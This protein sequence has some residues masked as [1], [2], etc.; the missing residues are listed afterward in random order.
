MKKSII[1]IFIMLLFS[2]ILWGQRVF[3][4]DVFG[5]SVSANAFLPTKMDFYSAVKCSLE[6]NNEIRAIRKA[7]AAT[8]KDVGIARSNMLPHAR[9]SETFEATNN[10][11]EAF[12]LKLNQTRATAK[13][14]SLG[15]LDYP[16]GVYNF[17]TTL[18]LEQMILN[19]KAMVTI[20][21]AKK[22]YSASEYAYIRK[23]EELIN[24]VAQTCLKIN[25]IKE[26]IKV[27][28]QGIKDANEHLEIAKERHSKNIGDYADVFRA[29]TAV[30][31]RE[32]KLISANKNL[33]ITQRALGLLLGMENP[34]EIIDSVPEVKLNTMC[35]YKNLALFRSDVIA[36]EVRVENAKNN[37][38]FEQA[39]W[40]PTLNAVASYNF[41]DPYYPFGGLGNNY[42][43]AAFLRWDIFDG[44]KRNYGVA[45]AKYKEEE[46][47]E[48]LEGFKKGVNFRI[49]EVYS[50]VVEHQ[51]NL[52]LA[53]ARKKA[54]EEGQILTEKDWSNSK[55]PFVSVIESQ[56]SLDATR[57]NL[58]NNQFDLQEDLITL[59]Y[60]SG[61]IY[62]AFNLN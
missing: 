11:I 29:Q 38:K 8:G 56:E 62:Q 51:K 40:Y 23:K 22:E 49:Y 20:K 39:D 32:Q 52:E 61:I 34:V 6:N 43:A 28:E 4:Q 3:A 41:Y 31:E 13:D 57:L 58:V 10:P 42:I 7:L 36:M 48:Y 24:K 12:A 1:F 53:I 44:M 5:Q 30:E 15:T 47:Q 26:T 9:F 16:G 37:I 19:K 45:K 27:I 59:I 18:S 25:T 33:D 60:E 17:L 46:A 21:M 14:L 35:Y 54:A 55:L 2:I 50:N